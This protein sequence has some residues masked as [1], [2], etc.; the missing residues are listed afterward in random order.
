M[1]EVGTTT[2]SVFEAYREQLD[3]PSEAGL[4][5]LT[6]REFQVSYRKAFTAG[7]EV[8]AT[9]VRESKR[10][11]EYRLLEWCRARRPDLVPKLEVQLKE[12]WG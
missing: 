2:G 12:R 7:G 6:G 8:L 9:H 5:V 4:R 10:R 1:S 11:S 3:Q